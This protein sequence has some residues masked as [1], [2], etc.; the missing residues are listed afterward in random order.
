MNFSS[1]L[2]V[3]I[4]LVTMI[5]IGAFGILGGQSTRSALRKFVFDRVVAVNAVKLNL[6]ENYVSDVKTAMSGYQSSATIL[7]QAAVLVD[8]QTKLRSS[9]ALAATNALQA[10]FR[11]NRIKYDFDDVKILN[12]DHKILYVSNEKYQAEVGTVAT[13]VLR[14][15]TQASE[16][17][18]SFSKAM[19]DVGGGA[20]SEMYYAS[21]MHDADGQYLGQ[22]VFELDLEDLFDRVADITGMSETGESY[23]GFHDGYSAVVLSPLKYDQNASLKKRVTFGDEQEKALQLAVQGQRGKAQLTDY[24][25]V[26]VLAAWEPFNELGWGLVTKIDYTE[27]LSP[28]QRVRTILLYAIPIALVLMV[29]C[30]VWIV[31]IFLGRPLNHLTKVAEQ[32]SN[33][34]PD[35]Q[36]EQKMLYSQDEFGH[37]ATYLHHIAHRMRYEQQGRKDRPAE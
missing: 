14:D 8:N 23:L 27:A 34:H 36:V 33:G 6:L 19:A 5:P 25:G 28:L 37:L 30:I 24:R 35:I 16:A 20:F 15:V 22:I 32:I 18:A 7:Q 2:I 10:A 29:I 17:S 13:G 4:L 3:V 9:V 21:P 1:R 31:Q 26:E 11:E 12:N